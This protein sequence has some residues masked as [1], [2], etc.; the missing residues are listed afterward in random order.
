MGRAR[1]L[2]RLTAAVVLGF[3]LGRWTAGLEQSV[4][5]PPGASAAASRPQLWTQGSEDDRCTVRRII[6][7]DTIDVD[8][9]GRRERVRLLQID[10]PER[11]QPGYRRATAALRSL[12]GGSE[13]TLEYAQPGR[14]TRGRYGRLLAYVFVDGINANVEMVRE[15]WTPYW[16]KYGRS[17]FEP[18]F[19]AAE[20]QAT[21]RRAQLTRR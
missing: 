19:L 6:D 18:D 9:A 4:V 10:T 17:R 21:L 8:C 14:P 16:T 20:R 11:G 2:V 12:I 5:R 13:V 3:V 1:S 7:G 15:G